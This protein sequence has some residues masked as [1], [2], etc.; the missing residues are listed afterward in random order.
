[1]SYLRIHQD[2]LNK[3]EQFVISSLFPTNS[4]H[5]TLGAASDVLAVV[6]SAVPVDLTNVADYC[7]QQAQSSWSIPPTVVPP[8]PH[9]FC[10]YRVPGLD[11]RH[12][13]FAV[14]AVRD[15]P[16]AA[17]HTHQEALDSLPGDV[18]EL[19]PTGDGLFLCVAHTF[20]WAG[21][22][23]LGPTSV[24]RWLCHH[25]GRLVRLRGGEDDRSFVY[26]Q[27]GSTGHGS[28]ASA[29]LPDVAR[30]LLQAFAFAHC[31]NVAQVEQPARYETRQERRAAERRGDKP[32]VR[33]YTLRIDPDATRAK[34]QDQSTPTSNSR[35]L[36]LHI[37][38]GHF[39]HYTEDKPLFGK[40]AGTFWVP[41]HVRGSADVG[42]VG[43]DYAVKAPKEVA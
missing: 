19:E 3:R 10:E 24:L 2:I 21:G 12:V 30:P 31:R 16:V 25:D 43:K 18:R 37:V 1:M 20:W 41:A 6:E 39:S 4:A 22:R 11:G 15:H 35:S 36:P 40:H 17:R 26:R 5:D 32:P 13:G 28:L 33:F 42:L 8:W 29:L 23:S 14:S 38:R 34:R 27:V 9:S 7:S